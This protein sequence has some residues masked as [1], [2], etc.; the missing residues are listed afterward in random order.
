MARRTTKEQA[1]AEL[2]EPT[3]IRAGLPRR[4]KP[5]P[6]PSANPDED[7]TQRPTWQHSKDSSQIWAMPVAETRDGAYVEPG[8]IPWL[9]LQVVGDS[10]GPTGGSKLTR[11]KYIQRVHTSGGTAPASGC[12][13]I[14][15]RALVPYTTDYYFWSERD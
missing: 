5:V 4:T 12:E 2:P 8:A 14:G 1:A 15:A 13:T 7:G 3:P 11:T 9:L 10:N 6:R